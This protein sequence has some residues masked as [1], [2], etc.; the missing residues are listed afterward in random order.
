MGLD[1]GSRVRQRLGISDGLS[2]GQRLE[3]SEKV[4]HEPI[5]YETSTAV[6]KNAGRLKKCFRRLQ[7]EIGFRL[8]CAAAVGYFRR[9]E[10][11]AQSLRPSEKVLP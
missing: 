2:G 7:G 8:A 10:W 1:F 5:G 4:C 9:P 6:S 3:P 11:V